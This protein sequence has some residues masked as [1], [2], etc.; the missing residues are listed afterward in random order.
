MGP[1]V[2]TGGPALA[3]TYRFSSGIFALPPRSVCRLDRVEQQRDQQWR[4]TAFAC[5]I[6]AAKHQFTQVPSRSLSR[7]GT[8]PTNANSVGVGQPFEPGMP[9]EI[10]V[11]VNDLKMLPTIEAWEDRAPP[12]SSASESAPATSS[13]SSTP[14]A[15]YRDPRL[16]NTLSA[17]GAPRKE[18]QGP[19]L[20]R[21]IR[22]YGPGGPQV[23]DPR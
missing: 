3:F 13:D 10:V 8:P 1:D 15:W 20:R 16:S 6:G 22:R 14:P 9:M 19:D 5:P 17:K 2:G 11:Q 21:R 12:S 18:R 7:R 23:V 4:V